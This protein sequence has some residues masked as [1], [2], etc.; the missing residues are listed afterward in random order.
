VKKPIGVVLSVS[1]IFILW[2]P[3]VAQHYSLIDLG[4]VQGGNFSEGG[5]VNNLGHVAGCADTANNCVS[6]ITGMGFLW[7]Q[8]NGLQTLPLLPSGGPTFAEAIND[9]DEAA[10]FS[11]IGGNAHAVLWSSSN[12]IQDLGT[13]PRGANSEARAINNLGQVTGYSD[14]SFGFGFHAFLWT[15]STGMRDLGASG[16][17]V[18][19]GINLSGH[20]S[21]WFNIGTFS[22]A[23]LWTEQRGIEDLGPLPGWTWSFAYGMNDLDDVVGISEKAVT[24]G[25]V[26]RAT[27]W[28]KSTNLKGMRNLGTL[29]GGVSSYAVA[30]NNLGQIVGSS[31]FKSSGNTLHAFVWSTGA[32][33][34][35]LN[36]LIP[37][38]SGWTLTWA[39]G[40]NNLGQITGYGTINQQ[41]HAFLLTPTH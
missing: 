34:Q 32:G 7:T 29:P 40:I 33:M 11:W 5:G 16:S 1:I 26:N 35:D 13:L 39:S 38:G 24:G 2:L 17:S 20:V 9:T 23:F 25:Y 14:G 8:S 18:G 36:L 4:T 3:A 28:S 22:H 15:S 31:D 37:A 41:I 27:L 19:Q 10:G 21:G 30:I 6:N 12:T